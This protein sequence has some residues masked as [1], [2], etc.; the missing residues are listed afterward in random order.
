MGEVGSER[1]CGNVK[2]LWAKM[3][4][5]LVVALGIALALALALAPGAPL[6]LVGFGWWCSAARA[7]GHVF[8]SVVGRVRASGLVRD[9]ASLVLCLVPS[10]CGAGGGCVRAGGV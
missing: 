4:T 2:Y 3:V 1:T 6:A 5:T 7:R 9:L 8:A 10:S